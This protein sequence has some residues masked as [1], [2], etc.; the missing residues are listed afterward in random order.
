MPCL[1]AQ[2]AYPPAVGRAWPRCLQGART[3]SVGTAGVGLR[4]A[5][6]SGALKTGED[7]TRD[8]CVQD[9]AQASR[10]AG[11]ARPMEPVH[12]CGLQGMSQGCLVGDGLHSGCDPH[13]GDPA[14]FEQTASRRCAIPLY[15]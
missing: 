15:C 4:L 1:V 7:G 13:A 14:A 11:R 12:T 6:R 8:A 5:H 2:S 9:W 10:S 3:V